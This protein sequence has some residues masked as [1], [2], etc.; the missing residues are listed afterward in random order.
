MSYLRVGIVIRVRVGR[1]AVVS[2]APV[3]SLI[4]RMS[5]LASAVLG[6]TIHTNLLVDARALVAE[7]STVARHLCWILLRF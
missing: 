1:I 6:L 4:Q 2:R 5:I 3:V 7:V